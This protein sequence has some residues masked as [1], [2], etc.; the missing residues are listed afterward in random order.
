MRS[1]KLWCEVCRCAQ[2]GKSA[3]CVR[4]GGGWKR[5]YGESYTGTKEETP[6]TD[7]GAPS[8]LPRQSSTDIP[9]RNLPRFN[10]EMYSFPLLQITDDAEQITGLWIPLRT[11]HA[12][13]AFARFT[14]NLG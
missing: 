11:E 2:Y 3:C 10:F 12:H 8:G 9:L 6:D 5:D 4:C 7:K 1:H 13:E 14:K